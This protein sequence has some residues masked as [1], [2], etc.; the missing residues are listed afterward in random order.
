MKLRYIGILFM[1]FSVLNGTVYSQSIN[2]IKKDKEKSEKEI[3]YLNKLLEEAKNNQSVSVEKLKIIQEK[4]A[5]SKSLINSLQQEVS[6]LEKQIDRNE[7]RISE[8]SLNRGSMLNMY[9]KLVYGLWKKRNK[10]YRLMF[11][12]ASSDFN[13]AYNRYKYFEQIQSYS[14]R[15]LALIE[16]TN[17][18]LNIKNTELKK[19]RDLKHV[20]LNDIDVKS[21]DLIQ[22]QATE[23]SLISDLKKKEKQIVKKLNIEAKNRER[24]ERELNK[25]IASQAKKSGGTSSKYKLTPEEKLVSDDFSR[26]KGKL[27]WPVTQGIISEKFG[28][29]PHPVY[30]DVMMSNNGINITTSKNA[31]VRAVFNGEVT[32]ISLMPGLNNAVIIRHGNYLT[33]YANLIYLNVKKGDKVNTKQVIGKV[34][35]D[36]EKGS[37]LSFQVWN[38]LEKQN[39]ELWLAK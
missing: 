28:I 19:Y 31:E 12:F 38:N 8:L 36:N 4:I 20:A 2:T 5:Q 30:K 13:Q 10:A 23:N 11:I 18:S 6:Y 37:V 29:N 3:A 26:N 27:P 1:F 14:K 25:L 7:V 21:K 22:Q 34:A 35:H 32:D 17:D 24:L 33:V 16:Q 39:P 9:G 15:Q